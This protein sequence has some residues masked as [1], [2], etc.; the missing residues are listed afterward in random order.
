LAARIGGGLKPRRPTDIDPTGGW[1]PR[2]GVRGPGAANLTEDL[3]RP[4]GGVAPLIQQLIAKAYPAMTGQGSPGPGAN[5]AVGRAL[6]YLYFTQPPVRAT[7]A[8]YG[9]FEAPGEL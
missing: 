4:K 9:L 1:S 6:M 2:L 5:D 8:A 3:L 7:F